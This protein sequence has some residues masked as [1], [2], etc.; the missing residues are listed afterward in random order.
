MDVRLP[1]GTIIANVPEGTT[2]SELMRRVGLMNAVETPKPEPTFMERMSTATGRGFEAIPESGT[3][4]SFGIKSALGMKPEASAT[5]E[6]I[7]KEKLADKGVPGISFEEL[8]KTYADKG[9]LETLKKTP[10]YIGEQILQ[11]APSM[12]IPIA[13]GSGVAAVSGPLAPITGPLAGIGTYGVQQFGNFM[14]RQ[15]EEGA[16]G[17]TAEPGKAA[18]TAAVTAPVGYFTDRLTL[19]LGKIPEKILGKEV[20]AELAK[21]TGAN[22]GTR[23]ATGATLGIVA[24]SPTEVLEQMAERWQ[25]GLPLKDDD[26][27]REYKEAFFGAAAVGGVGGAAARAIKRA[28]PAVTPP[29]PPPPPAPAAVAAQ[30]A[31]QVEKP[32]E[33]LAIGMS[34]PFTPVSLPDGSVALTK[35]DLDAYEQEQFDKKYA[36]QPNLNQVVP[37]ETPPQLGYSPL[38]GVPKITQDGTVLLTPEQEF[39]A[40]YA[41]QKTRITTEVWNAM[42]PEE[43]DAASVKAMLEEQQRISDAEVEAQGKVKKETGFKGRW[44]PEERAALGI[45]EPVKP[46]KPADRSINLEN[47]GVDNQ[48]ITEG[49][50][51]FIDRKQAV[52]AAKLQPTL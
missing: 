33:P 14:R 29:P 19:G 41:P 4:I 15:A 36:P 42:S 38:P 44:T 40:Q 3:G 52:E 37:A 2:Q 34:E 45:E 47:I 1:D 23:M 35:S 5:A 48:L 30:P 11:S 21:R 22:V 50:K 32:A 9:L 7:R 8:E 10:A 16:T 18:A 46:P 28:E 12:A 13:V 26:A 31:T 51:P 39:E 25:A 49:A 27:I 24:E 43:K 17:E 6:Q 20:A